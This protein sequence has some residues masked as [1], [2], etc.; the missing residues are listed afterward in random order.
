MT[1]ECLPMDLSGY[2]K[3]LKYVAK[4]AF[5]NDWMDKQDPMQRL[6]TQNL[7][8]TYKLSGNIR[9]ADIPSQNPYTSL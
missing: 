5:N 7:I 8:R 6:W 3:C 9:T 1:S 4:M 2:L